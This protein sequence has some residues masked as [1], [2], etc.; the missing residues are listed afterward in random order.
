MA[1]SFA[2]KA[3]H[4]QPVGN[5]PELVPPPKVGWKAPAVVG[6]SVERVYPVT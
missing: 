4:G 3:S 1:L 2:T 5:M 6:K